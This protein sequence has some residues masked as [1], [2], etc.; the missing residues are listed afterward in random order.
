MKK[1]N[2]LLKIVT[3]FTAFAVV[4]SLLNSHFAKYKEV[5]ATQHASNYSY[6][7]YSGTYYSEHGV[8]FNA[9]QGM[10]G[11][12]RT[13][14]TEEIVP[15][16]FPT[17]SGSGTN[18]I[19]DLFQ[20]SEQDPTNNSNMIY[21][22]TRDSVTKTAGTVNG[23]VIWNREHVWPKSLSNG[24]WAPNTSG[25]TSKAG[26]DLLHLRPTYPSTNSSRGNTMYGQTGS[27][28]EANVYNGMTWSYT[29]NGYFE[30]LDANKGDVARIIMYV[31]TAYQGFSGY[32]S[33]SI[34]DVFD[35]FDTLLTWHTQDKPDV[36]EGHRN[37][38]AEESLQK[39]RNPF[40]DH[41]ELAWEIFGDQVSPSVKSA[42]Q[43]TYPSSGYNPGQNDEIPATDIDVTPKTVSLLPG[44]QRQLNATLT[45]A[46]TTDTVSW[47]SS[48]TSIATVSSGGKVTIT[49]SAQAGSTVTITATAGTVS[50][51]C[52]VT[53]K[54][55]SGDQN[56]YLLYEDDI[57]EGD[58]IIHYNG[59]NLKASVS[60]NN[61]LEYIEDTPANNTLPSDSDASTIW[62]IAPSG[63]Y[64]TIYNTSTNKYA[65]ST[66]T[67]NQATLVN[68]VN[69]DKAL[70]TISKQSDGTF[71]IINKNNDSA[72]VNANLRNN[73]TYG[74]ACYNTQTGGSLSLYKK[75]TAI[76]PPEPTAKD[77]INEIKT[78]AAL[79]YT[80][81]KTEGSVVTDNLNG[82]FTGVTGG[83][84][85]DWSN[86]TDT[87]SA[88]YAGQS[89]GT[90]SSIQL[91]SKN[92][93]SGIITTTSGGKAAK[94]TVTWNGNTLAGRQ[95]D[96]YGKNT[97]YSSPTD[98]YGSDSGTLLGTITNGSSTV[99]SITG[100]YAYIGIRSKADAMYLD[101]IEIQWGEPTTFAF[102]TATV[103]FRGFLTKTL[104]D[105][106][107][108]ESTI[109]GFGALISTESYL[110]GAKLE[111]KYA[112][113]DGNNV[114]KVTAKT[115]LPTL[116]AAGQYDDITEDTYLWNLRRDIPFANFTTNYVAVAFIITEEDGVVFF[117]EITASVKS[118]AQDMLDTPELDDESYGGS[119]SYLANL[120]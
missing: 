111:T 38:V 110:N 93:N 72:G 100:D 25:A 113:A 60:S 114:T 32:N 51:T 92:N 66:G 34:T 3:F 28:R 95:L 91:R 8:D 88:V 31:W 58:Y 15:A 76:I 90:Y 99:L 47:S 74:F 80:C 82:A 97:A 63:N 98:L 42:C 10:N 1:K 86:K 55:T 107:D 44:E 61:R 11:A 54:S 62:H 16:R 49:N 33:L 108:T 13:K 50:D 41:P 64:Y 89:A 20:D 84:Y 45:P 48:N 36:L 39:N 103:R 43:S 18:T 14:L 26:T 40:V 27:N 96:V 17:Y 109:T 23:T 85:V 53:I 112:S 2:T 21:F 73:G 75:A 35:S 106:L 71:E 79:S 4:G 57:V 12:L 83:S 81:E 101:S 59:K 77:E 118:I 119:L 65:A 78:R 46:D 29:G 52:V 117:D 37:D 7:V 67:K 5:D 68:S 120:K 6:Y 87:S 9:T 69:S 30:P 116:L 94:V 104:W 19:S 115:A 24:N 102:T 70:W 56:G 105:Q 22:Y